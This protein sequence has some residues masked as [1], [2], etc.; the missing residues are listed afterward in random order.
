MLVKGATGD[1][2]TWGN[3]YTLII[4][5]VGLIDSSEHSSYPF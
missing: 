4:V 5:I 3:I 1:L 2:A